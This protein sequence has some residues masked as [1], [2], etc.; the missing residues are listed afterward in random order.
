MT[1]IPANQLWEV[2]TALGF[3]PFSPGEAPI[4]QGYAPTPAAQV[5]AVG[6]MASPAVH[7]LFGQILR[8]TGPDAPAGIELEVSL[9]MTEVGQLFLMCADFALQH[10]LREHPA[11]SW[12]C[13]AHPAS[14]VHNVCEMVIDA[15]SKAYQ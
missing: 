4:L 9:S 7:D 10:Q 6:A 15:I 1:E 3:R 12:I 5:F 8:A 13:C 2:L 14:V 11:N